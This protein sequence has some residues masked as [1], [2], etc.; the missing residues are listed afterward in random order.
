MWEVQL[1]LGGADLVGLGEKVYID[2]GKVQV[3]EL[4]LRV[5]CVCACVRGVKMYRVSTSP[6]LPAAHAN[7]VFVPGSLRKP[8]ASF[9]LS[10]LPCPRFPD[11][12]VKLMP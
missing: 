2:C 7:Q 8:A 6:L 5:V 11:T 3:A 4:Y 10:L 1:P 9:S 12:S